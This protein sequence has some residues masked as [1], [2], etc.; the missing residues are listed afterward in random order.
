MGMKAA[1]QAS[2]RGD[3]G[4]VRRLLEAHL[5]SAGTDL[6]RFEWFWLWRVYHNE[7]LSSKGT[8][9]LSI[10]SPSLPT[11][12]RLPRGIST[13]QSSC[14]WEMLGNEAGGRGWRRFRKFKQ[15]ST[16]HTQRSRP[17][18]GLRCRRAES[19]K[20][21]DRFG[22]C[23]KNFIFRERILFFIYMSLG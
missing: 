4:E 7:K 12:R 11:A 23:R 6:R 17:K 14:G 16:I 15:T 1:F 22:F 19:K 10:Q 5:P 18:T 8:T 9:I 21:L 20:P 13:T 3:A 2:E